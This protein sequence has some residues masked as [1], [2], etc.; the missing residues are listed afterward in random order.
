MAEKSASIKTSGM[1]CNSCVMLIE[2][3]VADLEGVESV[4]TDLASGSTE[5][6]YDEDK[7]RLDDIVAEIR[8]A[9]YDAEVPA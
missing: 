7:V 4:H 2:M 1:H 9:G 6:T 8:K 3:N 5:V